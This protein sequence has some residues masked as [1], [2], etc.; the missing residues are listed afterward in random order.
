M[1][2]KASIVPAEDKAICFA[3]DP[4]TTAA[5]NRLL[6]SSVKPWQM[7]TLVEEKS[8]T[9]KKPARSTCHRHPAGLSAH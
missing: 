6:E 5:L 9:N 7:E 8:S 2:E 3:Y 4:G 1:Q